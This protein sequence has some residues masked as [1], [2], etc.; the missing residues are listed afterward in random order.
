[1]NLV[2]AQYHRAY[3]ARTTGYGWATEH[4]DPVPAADQRRQE[5]FRQAELRREEYRRQREAE[6][7]QSMEIR[8]T[9]PGPVLFGLGVLISVIAAILMALSDLPQFL[10]VLPLL[11]PIGGLWI[12]RVRRTSRSNV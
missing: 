8:T 9:D 4:K 3:E 5:V 6:L 7:A 12:K 10:F 1:M 2:A 11:V